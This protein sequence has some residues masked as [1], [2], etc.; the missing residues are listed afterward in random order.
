M[1]IDRNGN[2]AM[3]IIAESGRKRADSFHKS[4]IRRR[5]QGRCVNVRFKVT[6]GDGTGVFTA[7]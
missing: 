2:Q 5:R 4:A 1:R 6:F 7:P 3:V